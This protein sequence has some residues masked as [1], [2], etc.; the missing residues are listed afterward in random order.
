[1]GA[2]IDKLDTSEYLKYIQIVDGKI[3]N[4][5]IN[6]FFHPDWTFRLFGFKN[7]M[8][9]LTDKLHKFTRELIKKRRPIFE[10]SPSRLKSRENGVSTANTEEDNV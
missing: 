9:T 5:G 1:M 7:E 4:R 2:D 3:R 8:I 6:P 10:S